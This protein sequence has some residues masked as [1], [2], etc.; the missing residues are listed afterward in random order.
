MYVSPDA[1]RRG[2]GRALLDAAIEASEA[3]GIW[4]LQAGIFPENAASLALHR[5][6]FRTVGVRERMGQP[7]GT[8]A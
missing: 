8:L 3:A 7:A 1:A 6:G 5:G 4:T 2:I